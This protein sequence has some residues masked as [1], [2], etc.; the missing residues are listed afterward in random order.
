MTG[1]GHDINDPFVENQPIL[2]D[3][4]NH[5]NLFFLYISF[6]II[7]R[8]NIDGSTWLL[9]RFSF[10]QHIV[11]HGLKIQNG[12]STDVQGESSHLT[13]HFTRSGCV[14]IILSASRYEL[15]DDIP[16]QFQFLFV[17]DT[18]C[19]VVEHLLLKGVEGLVELEPGVA[20]SESGDKNIGLGPSR[21]VVLDAGVNSFQNV[22][23]T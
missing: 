8:D 2:L 19:V 15:R 9:E 16:L 7:R 20:R 13:S 22:V 4:R 11:F 17:D 5:L 23:S 3:A 10:S 1:F 18:V 6:K 21:S 14:P 12:G